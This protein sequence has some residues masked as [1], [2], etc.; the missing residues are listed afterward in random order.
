MIS[1]D[2]R[3]GLYILIK[4]KSYEREFQAKACICVLCC[5]GAGVCW[6]RR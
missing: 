5:D 1:P 2:R 6:L 4:E 3:S